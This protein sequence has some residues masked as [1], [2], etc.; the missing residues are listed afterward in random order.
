MRAIC[1]DLPVLEAR[2]Q[3]HAHFWQAMIRYY[4][5]V[6]NTA[7]YARRSGCEICSH[8]N[9]D[10]WLVSESNMIRKSN[11]RVYCTEN[12]LLAST[13]PFL[14]PM[15][16]NFTVLDGEYCSLWAGIVNLFYY[17]FILSVRTSNQ[18][19]KVS[20]CDYGSQDPLQ[21]WCFQHTPPKS[22]SHT[23]ATYTYIHLLMDDIFCILIQRVN[24]MV[25]NTTNRFQYPQ[26]LPSCRHFP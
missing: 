6:F 14:S 21:L 22:V 15:A 13:L 23:K 18:R 12:M 9:V 1:D 16:L 25:Y 19:M 24:N 5:K 2:A 8:H 17:S 20:P 26:G 11:T 10:V 3:H 4:D 7:A